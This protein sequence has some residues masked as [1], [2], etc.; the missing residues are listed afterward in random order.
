M[1][2][3]D[4]PSS[5]CPLGV[6]AFCTCFITQFY[7]LSPRN[8]LECLFVSDTPLL[9]AITYYFIPFYISLPMFQLFLRRNQ[10]HMGVHL[11]HPSNPRRGL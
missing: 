11:V 2:Q 9:V 3:A 7:F 10:G 6:M 5:V 8:A 4:A 1:G